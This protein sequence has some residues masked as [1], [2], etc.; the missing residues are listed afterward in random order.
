MTTYDEA[1]DQVSALCGE[2]G[3]DC[4]CKEGIYFNNDGS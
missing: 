4:E 3:V 1:L 2:T